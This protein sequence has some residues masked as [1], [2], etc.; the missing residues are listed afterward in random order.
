MSNITRRTIKG[1]HRPIAASTAFPWHQMRSRPTLSCFAWRRSFNAALK[2]DAEAV[3]AENE[4]EV[5]FEA[6]VAAAALP[7]GLP[8]LRRSGSFQTSLPPTTS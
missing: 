3:V 7:E 5:A 1:R 8:S 2:L 6:E 4:A